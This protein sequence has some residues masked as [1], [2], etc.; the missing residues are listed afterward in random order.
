MLYWWSI[1]SFMTYSKSDSN[2][3]RC[4]GSECTFFRR[5]PYLKFLLP[6]HGFS[7]QLLFTLQC[8]PNANFAHKKIRFCYFF[9]RLDR[10]QTR[11]R[12]TITALR[13]WLWGI[14]RRALED[15]KD[16]L[17]HNN[18]NNN[19]TIKT[20][21]PRT[22]LQIFIPSLFQFP[23]KWRPN[24]T[25]CFPS[26][27][28]S[29]MSFLWPWS[30]TL[31]LRTP[32]L[33]TTWITTTVIPCLPPNS[34]QEQQGCVFAYPCHSLLLQQVSNAISDRRHQS[35]NQNTSLTVVS[36]KQTQLPP[37]VPKCIMFLYHYTRSFAPCT[38]PPLPLVRLLYNYLTPTIWYSFKK[39]Q[40]TC[41]T[42]S[43][44]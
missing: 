44:W 27:R 8:M 1:Q 31:G 17:H 3:R 42:L 24:A 22:Q 7:L 9:N 18:N 15:T 23:I 4:T 32:P 14:W 10:C 41:S 39:R 6:R 5:Q 26:W 33:P 43:L 16:H 35:A 36:K 37:L 13:V 2:W 30:N 19:N 29:S 11:T 34:K 12:F 20:D 40:Q 25:S 21:R 38:L 28:R